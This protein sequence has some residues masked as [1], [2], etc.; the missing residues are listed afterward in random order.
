VYNSSQS[1][2][3]N[4][5]E[6]HSDGATNHFNIMNTT[7]TIDNDGILTF[8]PEFLEQVGWKEGDVLQWID[9]HDGSWTLTKPDERI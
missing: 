6:A 1:C 7:L 5:L 9:N 2:Y 4:Y 8:P 3:K